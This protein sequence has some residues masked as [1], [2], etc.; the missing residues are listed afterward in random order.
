MALVNNTTGARVLSSVEYQHI[1]R[2][3][4]ARW[5]NGDRITLVLPPSGSDA[6][7]ALCEDLNVNE[8]LYRRHLREL[9]IRGEIHRPIE[10]TT[11][12]QVVDLV[13]ATPG[14]VAPTT[15][16]QSKRQ[17]SLPAG[18]ALIELPAGEE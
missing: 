15:P 3:T 10:A 11:E 2:G 7:R 4:L 16:D 5:P 14:T 9:A 13:L 17:E 8:R 18:V 12:L 1:F 6:M